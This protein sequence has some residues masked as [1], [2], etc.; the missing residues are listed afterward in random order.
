VEYLFLRHR[1]KVWK[2]KTHFSSDDNDFGNTRNR[3]NNVQKS[4]DVDVRQWMRTNN[5]HSHPHSLHVPL[6]IEN[7]TPI[8]IAIVERSLI[9]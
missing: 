2:Q 4:V 8:I 3:R 5:L 6:R 1:D 9:F 7:S